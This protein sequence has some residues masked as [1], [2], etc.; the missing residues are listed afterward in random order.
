MDYQQ[1]LVYLYNQFPM[2]QRIGGLAYKASLDSTLELDAYFGHPHRNFATIHVGGTNGKGSSAHQL[3]A[4]LQAAGFRTALF[5][6]PHLADFRERIRVDGQMMPQ[7][8][9]VGWVAAHRAYFEVLQPSFFEMSVAMAFDYFAKQKVDVAVVEVGMGGRLD[10]TNVIDPVVS[11]ITNIG[12]D[13]T[14]FLGESLEAIAGEKAGI[15]KPSRPVVVSEWQPE[16][17]PVFTQKAAEM[18]AQLVW[19]DRVWDIPYGMQTTD[20]LQV[21]SPRKA[22]EMR[23]PMLKM[24]LMGMYQRKNLAGVLAT[25]DVLRGLAWNITDV[26]IYAGLQSVA[27]RTGLMGRWQIVG[28]NPLVVADT[29]HNPDGIAQTMAQVSQTAH[30]QLHIVL[31]MVNDKAHD[32]VLAL[33]P[34]DA[35]YY[36]CRAELPRSLDAQTLADMAA[37]FGLK[38][39]VYATVKLAADAARECANVHDLVYIGGSTFVVA[40]FLADSTAVY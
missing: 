22:G 4:I 25:V 6:S 26:Q 37:T 3:A 16:T 36:F 5:T 33:L 10:S 38:G 28:N 32:K 13:H 7:A 27:Q 9:V 11:L 23:Y 17:E 29:A 1:T 21:F 14:A 18:D 40:D 30:K 2:F 39:K 19:A 35:T 20:G 15:I 31:G 34:T 8:E 12:W 24:D